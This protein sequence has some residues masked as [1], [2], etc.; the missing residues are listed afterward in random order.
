PGHAQSHIG[1]FREKDGVFLGGDHLLAHISP[2]P[3]LEP[4]LPGHAERPKPQLQYNESLKKLRQLPISLFYSGHGEDIEDVNGLINERLG[5]Q[6]ERAMKVK[7]WL[8]FES[9]T[10]FEV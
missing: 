6:H 2:N 7:T 4:P 5:R 10:V 9:L 3:I 1:L 8:E